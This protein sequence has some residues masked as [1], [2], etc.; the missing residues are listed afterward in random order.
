M[1]LDPLALTVY[2]V[3]HSQTEERWITMGQDADGTLLVVVH[4][5]QHA[6]S[7]SAKV[8]LISAREATKQERRQ[9]EELPR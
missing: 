2:D 6:G 9:Y 4:T 5:F 3:E 7:I 8:R 1:F